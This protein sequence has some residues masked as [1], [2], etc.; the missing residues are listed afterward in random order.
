MDLIVERG[1]ELAAIEIKSGQTV[2]R[3]YFRGLNRFA[4]ICGDRIK[5][6]AVVYGGREGQPR[7]DW[8]VWP[9]R[10]L[11]GL[12]EKIFADLAD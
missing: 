3:D 4:G 2:T 11:G 6:G 8:E 9:I 12:S 5:S 1:R 10:D 7:S